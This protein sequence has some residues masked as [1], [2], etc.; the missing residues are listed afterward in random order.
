[1]K[2]RAEQLICA[3]AR[4]RA[5]VFAVLAGLLAL[6]ALAAVSRG[7]F[8]N[9][10]S[11]LFP[12][13]RETRA[14]FGI[15]HD[16]HLADA[17]QLEFI[18]AD[19]VTRHAAYLE[20]TAKRLAASPMLKQV[21][22]RYRS[23]DPAAELAGFVRLAP[24]FL[25]P[26]VLKECSPE[27]AAKNALKQ[28]AFPAPGLARR[29]RTQPFGWETGLLRD[30]RELDAATG[31]AP[32]PGFPFFVT[33]D[34][35]RAMI[36]AETGVRL[37]DA[38]AVRKLF[39]ELRRCAEPIPGGVEMRIVSGCSHTLGNEEVL[40]RDAALAGGVSLGLFL[41]LFLWAYRGD[42][43]A[44]WIPLLPLGAS[45]LTLGAMT[46]FFREICFY[47]IGLG[48]CVTGLAVDQGIHVYAAYR[49]RDAESKVAALVPPMLLSAGTSVVVFAFLALTGIEAYCQLAF[50]AGLSLTLSAVLALTVLPLLLDRGRHLRRICSETPPRGG[51]RGALVL[52]L[53]A[54]LLL[55]P[56]LPKVLERADFALESLDG[57]P[58]KTLAE[59]RDFRRAWHRGRSGETAVLAAAGRDRE[60]AFDRLAG[61]VAG[62]RARKIAAAMP[63]R[64]TRRAQEANRRAWRTPETAAR[65]AELKAA[66]R[67]ACRRHGLPEVF[68]DPFFTELAAAVAAEDFSLPPI[69][70]HIDR[71]M[72]KSHGARAAAVALL[73]DTPENVRAVRACLAE[74]RESEAALLSKGAFRALIRE[75]LGGR[76]LYL[77][78]LSVI[79]ALGLVWLVFRDLGDV[80]RAMTPVVFAWAAVVGLAYL[81]GFRATPAAA[82]AMV[83]LTGLAADYGI[84]AVCQCRKPDELDTRDPIL[85]SAATTVAGSGALLLSQHPVLFG[86]GMVL[87]PGIFAACLCGVFIVPRLCGT[88]SGGRAVVLLFAAAPL[89][90]LSGC[91]H[92]VPWE[93]YPDREALAPRM[94]RCPDRAFRL[95]AVT[96]AAFPGREFRFVLSAAVDPESGQVRCAGVDPG[97]GALLFRCGGASGEAPK[98]G[99][100]LADAAPD[101]LIGFL[102]GLPE[103]LRRIFAVKNAAPLAVEEKA[104]Y[105]VICAE[106]GVEWRLFR[107][108]TAAARGGGFFSGAWSAEYRDG[109]K[110]VRYRRSGLGGGYALDLL[111]GKIW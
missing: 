84:Y 5:A 88:R 105:I 89:F 41:L 53:T 74:R 104:E 34:R 110:T 81:T 90:F 39:A 16:A 15:L 60:E 59:E 13:T 98:L 95:Q 93:T 108:G 76:F 75:E 103:D 71:Q 111:I 63:P 58:E 54:V 56:A 35:R 29:L 26:S 86:T 1:M 85:L 19:D 72:I 8:T 52:A 9:D 12:D 25:D 87:A 61:I 62:L 27:N 65:I 49:G 44:L 109:G 73:A 67:T 38:D 57:T 69:L 22:F 78:G 2:P 45:L 37:G 32:D 107:D 99:P 70:E 97:S 79:A 11:R 106:D 82:F 42:R 94:R 102:T 33:S 36:A 40:K 47:V 66:C 21:V 28:L 101:A 68:F 4:H 10:L 83:L 55:V 18:A 31:F 46:F 51:R 7:R 20:T 3:C 77:L 96:R 6:A 24:R 91:A 100:A 43:R 64:P 50:F 48:G 30:L 14:V 80:L 23:D 17:V 92:T